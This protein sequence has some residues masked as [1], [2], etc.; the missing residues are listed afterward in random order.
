MPWAV[1]LW[2]ER[3]GVRNILNLG[4]KLGPRVSLSASITT[5]SCRRQK[6]RR[7]RS[8]GC[9]RRS[10][11]W[12]WWTPT[13]PSGSPS[14]RSTWDRGSSATSPPRCRTPCPAPPASPTS[15]STT[16]APTLPSRRSQR[17]WRT[18]FCSLESSTPK[19]ISLLRNQLLNFS[20]FF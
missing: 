2:D 20:C 18:E 16:L 10:R 13:S 5:S 11:G 6:T 14:T 3:D 4:P 15:T 9:G 19:L 8:T 1:S 7:R 17:W 12:R